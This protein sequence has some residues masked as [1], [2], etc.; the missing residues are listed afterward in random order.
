MTLTK[1]LQ[2]LAVQPTADG[3]EK[4]NMD[5]SQENR[6]KTLKWQVV[7]QK[8]EERIFKTVEET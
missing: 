6:E 5:L 1:Y 4:R 8:G 7:R 3:G 2:L